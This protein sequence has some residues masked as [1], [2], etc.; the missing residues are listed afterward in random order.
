M[1]SA[2]VGQ[3]GLTAKP[4]AAGAQSPPRDDLVAVLP[5]LPIPVQPVAAHLVKTDPEY[6]AL[7]LQPTREGELVDLLHG[8]P[9]FEHRPE[10]IFRR[11]RWGGLFLFS[12]PS[13]RQT[14]ALAKQFAAHGFSVERGPSRC[15]VGWKLPLFGKTYHYFVARKVLLLPPGEFTDRFTYALRLV[16]GRDPAHPLVVEKTVPTF[17]ALVNRLSSKFPDV[18]REVIEK[19]ARKFTEKIF[20]LFL[21]REA[22]ILLVLNEH[23]PAA[24]RSRVPQ[25]LDMEKDDRGFVRRLQMTWLR[26]GG[27][28]LTHMQFAHQSADLLRVIHDVAHVIH[29]D[30]RLDNMVITPDGVGFVDF[31]SAIKDDEDLS[32]NPLLGQIFGELMKTSQIQRMLDHMSNSGQVTNSTLLNGRQ[33]ADKAADLFYLALQY[34]KPHDN[35][36]LKDLIVFDPTSD[37]AMHLGRLTQE[38]LRPKDP[39]TPTY[40]SAKD[41]LHGVERIMLG[42]DNSRH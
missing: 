35:P 42:L 29:L 31:G 7:C 13:R 38:V 26:N 1:S 27:K 18:S 34:Q 33:K 3:P 24:Y 23:L 17:E 5:A 37:E 21:T 40:R 32:Q 39:A 4:D 10:E 6:R 11:L 8:S 14:A 22:G 9:A 19:R 15:R 25:L 16:A 2:F 30:L 41:L 20:P 12:G 28:P 36:D